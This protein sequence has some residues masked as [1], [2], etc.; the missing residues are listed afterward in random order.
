MLSCHICVGARAR[1]ESHAADVHA[2]RDVGP[3]DAGE[4]EQEALQQP[5]RSVLDDGQAHGEQDLTA[6]HACVYKVR[7]YARQRLE[8]RWTRFWSKLKCCSFAYVGNGEVVL[9]DIL[10]HNFPPTG[11]RRSV[12]KPG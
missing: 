4:R 9:L 3:L 1:Q 12:K 5:N 8:M 11:S 10:F 2:A 7:K 6:I